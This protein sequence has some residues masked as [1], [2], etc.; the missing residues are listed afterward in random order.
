M[1]STHNNVEGALSAL[2]KESTNGCTSCVKPSRRCDNSLYFS[3][4]I[5]IN[6]L[7]EIK[8]KKKRQTLADGQFL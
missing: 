7:K 8:G 2:L 1:L 4:V 3:P 6:K 5:Y